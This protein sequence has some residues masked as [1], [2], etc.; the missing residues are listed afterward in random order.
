MKITT[1]CGYSNMIAQG[2]QKSK[3][4]EPKNA[5]INEIKFDYTS[6]PG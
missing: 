3:C 5:F 2:K 4:C 1:S 6:T